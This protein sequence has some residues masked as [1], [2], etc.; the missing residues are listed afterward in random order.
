MRK[1]SP[2]G[3]GFYQHIGTGSEAAARRVL[4]LIFDLVSPRS[5]VDIGCGDGSWL[6][7]ATSLGVDEVLGVDGPWVA[8]STRKI[9][10]DRSWRSTCPVPSR[11]SVTSTW[12]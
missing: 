11:S 9:P 2:Y 5:M 12:R 10:D 1:H 3:A 6:Q 7:V 4:P 8:A